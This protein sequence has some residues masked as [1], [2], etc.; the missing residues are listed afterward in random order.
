MDNGVA[1][2]E[3][4]DYAN[5]HGVDV[6]VTDH[7]ELPEHCQMHTRLIHPRHPEGDYPFGEL[8]GVGVA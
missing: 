8:S 1:G 5:Q 2:H 4:I 6:V 7:H 3:A